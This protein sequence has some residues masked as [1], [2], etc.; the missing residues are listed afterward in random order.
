MKINTEYWEGEFWDEEQDEHEELPHSPAS[1]FSSTPA[2]SP[3][4][5]A[6][7]TMYLYIK[8]NLTTV[9]Q[10]FFMC[11]YTIGSVE[12]FAKRARLSTQDTGTS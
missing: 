9:K 3:G 6:F 2:S 5:I 7:I 12:P 8:V 10:T 1:H 4:K 11:N